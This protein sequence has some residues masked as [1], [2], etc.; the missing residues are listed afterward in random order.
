MMIINPGTEARDGATEKN[1]IEVAKM[2]AKD[3]GVGDRKIWERVKS[4]DDEKGLFG[5][6]FK[7]VGGE[8]DVDIPGD[9]PK[10]TVSNTPFKS[11]RLY[12][13]GSSWLYGYALGFIK[14]AIKKEVI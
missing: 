6:V 4:R 12:V 14:D 11:R 8:V 1:A 5:F 2:I 13:D 9:D 7:G 10:V 3:L